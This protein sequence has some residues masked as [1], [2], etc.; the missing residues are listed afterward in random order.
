MPIAAL[1][2]A[3]IVAWA[4]FG[5]GV[6][7]LGIGLW[8][9]IKTAPKKAKAAS[10]DKLDEAKGKVKELTDE[11]QKV[12]EGNLEVAAVTDVAST[13]EAAKSALEQVGS[14]V[15]SLPEYQ[16]FA[17]MLI[18]MGAVLMGVGTVQ[19]GGTSLF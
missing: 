19:F 6:I 12:K 8:M 11:L 18:L 5:I 16:R 15:G 3:D 1:N 14:I 4:C 13:A 10:N 9:G 2:N 17:G 7:V